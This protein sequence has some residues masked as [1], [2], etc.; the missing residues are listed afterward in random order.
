[1]GTRRAS[2]VSID[3][4]IRPGPN[5]L[6]DVARRQLRADEEHEQQVALFVWADSDATRARYPA[7]AALYAVPNFSIRLNGKL[8]HIA[9]KQNARL[10]AEGKRPGMW[11]VCLPAG[12]GGW[13]SLRI[14]MKTDRGALSPDQRDWERRLTALGNKCEVH[15]S[16]ESA[17]DAILAYLA[18]PP[19]VAVVPAA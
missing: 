17:R 12:H 5:H 4:S 13:L 1:M 2:R 8:A 16:W 14:E 9:K 6:L 10:R 7:V 15:R 18:L 19:T 3:S 11:D